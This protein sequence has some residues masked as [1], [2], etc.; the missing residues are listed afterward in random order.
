MDTMLTP[1]ERLK[2]KKQQ[3]ALQREAELRAA[4]SQAQQNYAFAQKKMS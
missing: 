4:T 1:A 2:L 3:Q